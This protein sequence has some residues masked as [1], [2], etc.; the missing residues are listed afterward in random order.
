MGGAWQKL[1]LLCLKARQEHTTSVVMFDGKPVYIDPALI[2]QESDPEGG[3]TEDA[4]Y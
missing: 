4:G 2:P 3:E 1:L